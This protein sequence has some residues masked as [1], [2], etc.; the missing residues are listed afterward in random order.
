MTRFQPS[1]YGDVVSLYGAPEEE[2]ERSGAETLEEFAP[3]IS[4]LLFGADSRQQYGKKK[5]QLENYTRLYNSSPNA[6]LRGLYANKIRTLQGE[7]RALG[8]EAEEERAAVAITQTG[9]IGGVILL[10]AGTITVVLIGNYVRQKTKT[11]KL[12]RRALQAKLN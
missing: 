3:A 10:V 6:F 9:K 11:E 8:E 5:A 2:E 12:T 1:T 4:Q 7:L